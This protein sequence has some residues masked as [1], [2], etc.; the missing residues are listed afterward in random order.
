MPF[1]NRRD[2]ITPVLHKLHWLP[3]HKRIDFKIASLTFKILHDREPGYLLELITRHNPTRSL[4][5]SSQLLLSVPRIDTEIGRRSFLFAAPT[6]WNS[7]PFSVR[8]CSS[9]SC[10]RSAL[11]TH[12]FPPLPP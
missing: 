6:I 4:R 12:L 3:I 9:L 11:K 2:H 5:S 8:S 10:F 7:L 1:V